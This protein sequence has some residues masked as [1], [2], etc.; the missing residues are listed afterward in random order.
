[1]E[2]AH[3]LQCIT[4]VNLD[5]QV[6]QVER[7]LPDVNTND[8]SVGQERVLVRGSGNLKTLGSR[9]QALQDTTVNKT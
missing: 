6:L 8:R 5:V 1:M 2:C 9:V 4:Y 3:T 7:V